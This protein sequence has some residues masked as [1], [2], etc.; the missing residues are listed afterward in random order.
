MSSGRHA[1]MYAIYEHACIY[2]NMYAYTNHTYAVTEY[3]D[4]NIDVVCRYTDIQILL[5]MSILITII[6]MIII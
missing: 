5:K 4:N 6:I 2:T 3:I 1:Y